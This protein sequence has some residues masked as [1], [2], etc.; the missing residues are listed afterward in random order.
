MFKSCLSN[1]FQLFWVFMKV[2][3]INNDNRDIAESY[4]DSGLVNKFFVAST[5]FEEHV[6]ALQYDSLKDSLNA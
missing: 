1:I 3:P 2:V 5:I 4:F 6:Q